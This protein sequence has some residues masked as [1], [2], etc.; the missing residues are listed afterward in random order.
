M[1][2]PN[3]ENQMLLCKR[4]KERERGKTMLY[5]SCKTSG[6][7]DRVSGF[8]RL[9]V[10]SL[11][12]TVFGFTTLH[13]QTVGYTLGP[14]SITVTNIPANTTAATIPVNAGQLQLPS[15]IVNSPDGTRV[16]ALFE[17]N[18]IVS[19]AVLV[20]DTASNTVVTTVSPV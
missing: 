20:I 12:I 19:S 5:Q 1:E 17:G 2:S 18:A 10:F 4:K 13:A 7:R 15:V 11:L 16:Y 9:F 8:L 6:N 14:G 3:R